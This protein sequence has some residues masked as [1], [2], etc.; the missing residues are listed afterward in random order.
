MRAAMDA[1]LSDVDGAWTKLKKPQATGLTAKGFSTG[2]R[3]TLTNS[4]LQL[5]PT[6]LPPHTSH[7]HNERNSNCTEQ[8]DED[9]ATLLFRTNDRNAPSRD[10]WVDDYEVLEYRRNTEAPTCSQK[11]YSEGDRWRTVF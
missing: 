4:V 8:E 6:P 11:P 7:G 10:P 1:G 5:S 9:S 3:H 2:S